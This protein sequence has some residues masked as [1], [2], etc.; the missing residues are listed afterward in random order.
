MFHD[1]LSL[2][3][4]ICLLPAAKQFEPSRLVEVAEAW[5][6]PPDGDQQQREV[7]IRS[8][9]ENTPWGWRRYRMRSFAGFGWNEQRAS[10]EIMWSDVKKAFFQ[11]EYKCY[12]DFLLYSLTLSWSIWC[13][14]WKG[15]VLCAEQTNSIHFDSLVTILIWNYWCLSSHPALCKIIFS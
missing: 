10:R 8:R 9:C 2:W 15:R 4:C 12:L 7:Y 5:L 13:H 3:R 6:A 14:I 11:L 1:A